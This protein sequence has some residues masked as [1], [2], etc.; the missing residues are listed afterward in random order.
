MEELTGK[1]GELC[2]WFL[3]LVWVVGLQLGVRWVCRWYSVLLLSGTHNRQSTIAQC[4][5][6]TTGFDVCLEMVMMVVLVPCALVCD[7]GQMSAWST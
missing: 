6:M 5:I 2:A 1:N 7:G 3:A 4:T